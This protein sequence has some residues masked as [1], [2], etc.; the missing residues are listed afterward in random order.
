[1]TK[2]Q[3]SAL[4]HGEPTEAQRVCNSCAAHAPAE[5]AARLAPE[6]EPEA[7]AMVAASSPSVAAGNATSE[8]G[9]GDTMSDLEME[10]QELKLTAL[11]KRALSAGVAESSMED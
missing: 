1:M 11:Q 2:G 9:V 6:P 8:A 10:L 7:Q 4:Q 3:G 5:V